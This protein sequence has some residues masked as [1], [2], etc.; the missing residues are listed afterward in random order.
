MMKKF[1]RPDLLPFLTLIGGLV[2]FLLRLWTLGSGP[3]AEAL[4][5]P[6]PVAWVLLWAVSI[7]VLALIRWQAGRLR[8]DG[9]H[10]D[11]YPASPTAAVGNVL[12]AV[13]ILV[14]SLDMILS[15]YDVLSTAGGVLGVLSAVCLIPVA[16]ARYQG[17]QPW[18]LLHFPP[19]LFLAMRIFDQCR[20]WSGHSQLGVFLIPFLALIFLLV[21]AHQK[22]TFDVGLGVRKKS[23]FW[24]LSSAYLCIVSLAD[25]DDMLFFGCMAIWMI[26]D[27][28]TLRP[29]KAPVPA[30][31][32]ATN[33]E[34]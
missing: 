26:T 23:V 9:T 28:C 10:A 32:E 15:G 7:L 34:E 16:V 29:L 6:Q 25:Q 31:E 18:F 27:L 11:C 2:G 22:T 20:D 17:K 8:V 4:Y 12:A 13:G 21:A 24:S 33:E 30:E 1:L 3:D 5:A 19:C 14:P